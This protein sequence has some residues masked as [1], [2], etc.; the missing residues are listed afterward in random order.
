MFRFSVRRVLIMIQ[1]G[2]FLLFEMIICGVAGF[3][4]YYYIT[5]HYY[6]LPSPLSMT[7]TKPSPSSYLTGRC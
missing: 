4:L 1:S 7:T 3:D 6:F 5:V 2:S